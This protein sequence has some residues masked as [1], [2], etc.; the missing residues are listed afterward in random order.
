MK[1][2]RY[3]YDYRFQ[4]VHGIDGPQVTYQRHPVAVAV[5]L[6][7]GSVGIAYCHQSDCFH[8]K[9]ARNVAT[10]R[11]QQ[12]KLKRAPNRKITDKDGRRRHIRDV[13]SELIIEMHLKQVEVAR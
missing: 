4:I 12:K 5:T 1:L 11:A 3:A 9:L 2:I 13:V 8:K 10:A 7:D 6:E